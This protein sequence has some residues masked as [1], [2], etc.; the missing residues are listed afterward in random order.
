MKGRYLG[1]LRSKGLM[2]QIF[3]ENGGLVITRGSPGT[4]RPRGRRACL[5]TWPLGSP[6]R[7]LA[8]HSGPLR[9]TTPPAGGRR[10]GLHALPS[11]GILAS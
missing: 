11:C 5:P 8:G 6:S 1:K 3:N 2:C 9:T 7:P 4:L 10:K